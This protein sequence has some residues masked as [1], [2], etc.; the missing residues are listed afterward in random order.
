MASLNVVTKK[1]SYTAA[2]ERLVTNYRNLVSA[3]AE[4][5]KAVQQDATTSFNSAAH[6]L[7]HIQ[8]AR[9]GKAEPTK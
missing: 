5:D 2:D 4:H 1:F 7:K 6:V 3:M 8:A 9:N